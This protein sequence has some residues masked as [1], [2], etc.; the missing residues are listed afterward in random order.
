M[1]YPPQPGQGYP[2]QQ[3]GQGYP[4][5]PGQ[6]Y[7]PQQPGQGYPPQQPGY[8]QPGAPGGYPPQPG[9]P[10]YPP[11]PGGHGPMPGAPGGY[12]P[13][14]MP[15]GAPGMPPGAPG[16][17]GGMP[18]APGAPG[19]IRSSLLNNPEV[20][21]NERFALQN[22][23][24]LKATL[25]AQGM[26]EFYARAGSMVAY[27]GGATFDSHWEGWASHL[28]RHFTGGEGL[29][30]MK[31]AGQGAVY[32]AYQAQDIHILDISSDPLT[33]D[34]R[35]V[36]AFDRDLQWD[37]VR[38]DTQ[39]GIAGVGNYQIELRGQ[40]KVCMCTTGAPLV[41]H[42]TPMNYYFADADA[43]V[44]WSS[45]LQVS[46]QAAVTSSSAWRPRGNTG[47]S[48]QMQFSGDG[49]V[50]IQPNELMPPYNALAGTDMAGRFGL[51]QQG[52]GGNQ[53]GGHGQGG[54]G[55]G[56]MGGLFGGGGHGQGGMGGLFGGGG[57][58][59]RGGLFG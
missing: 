43:V 13:G 7:P 34:G 24:M 36:L 29:N 49:Y 56:G 37:V 35:N 31:V 54:H 48:W 47:E 41:M 2:P 50:V 28:R 53:L 17:P 8:P 26:R 27:Q 5:Q 1:S 9:G 4:P 3:P 15:P 39:V 59:G 33:I 19:G 44:G 14:G 18:G 40:G 45:S 20:T 10:G 11:Q 22:G 32:L 55:Q 6:G 46:M 21:S 42:V 52:F 58:H 16:M 57:G 23:K 38:I 30:L 12:P 51:G 25:G